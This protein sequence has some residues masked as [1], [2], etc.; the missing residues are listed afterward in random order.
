MKYH[1]TQ[2]TSS[3]H[4]PADHKDW[5]G[6]KRSTPDLMD[7][8]EF[9]VFLVEWLPFYLAQGDLVEIKATERCKAS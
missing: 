9:Q 5:L 4:A 6:D 8:T 2:I 7:E 1:V 3:N